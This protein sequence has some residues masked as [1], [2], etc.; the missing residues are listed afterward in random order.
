MYDYS[1]MYEQSCGN[2]QCQLSSVFLI[3]NF[4]ANEC[5]NFEFEDT[6]IITRTFF[7]LLTFLTFQKTFRLILISIQWS[8]CLTISLLKS[9][10]KKI[11]FMGNDRKPRYFAIFLENS[12]VWKLYWRKVF[13]HIFFRSS[14]HNLLQNFRKNRKKGNIMNKN[15]K[16]QIKCITFVDITHTKLGNTAIS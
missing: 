12:A 8:I 13:S 5:S 7:E 16:I 2:K 1:I 15:N 4:N 10:S 9:V 3:G 11:C 14:I 6:F